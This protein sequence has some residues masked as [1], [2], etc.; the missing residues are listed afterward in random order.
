MT[1]RKRPTFNVR[2]TPEQAERWRAAAEHEGARDVAAWLASLAG[3]RLRQLGRFVPRRVLVWRRGSF[4]V[5]ERRPGEAGERHREVV[6]VVAGPFGIHRPSPGFFRLVH[7]P[8]GVALTTLKKQK[9]CKS[10]ARELTRLRIH[11]DATD[12]AEVKGQDTHHLRDTIQRAYHAA[13]PGPDRG[14]RPP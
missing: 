10:L 8:T 1:G 9:Q 2:A 12:P 13:Y 4:R 5:L 3:E 11:W 6:G 7:T 14:L